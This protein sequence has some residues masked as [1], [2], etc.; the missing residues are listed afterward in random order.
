MPLAIRA[1]L[2][3]CLVAWGDIACAESEGWKDLAAPESQGHWVRPSQGLDS[4]P[5]WGHADGL[6][7]GLAPMPGPR[8]LLRV[9]APYLGHPPGRMINYVAVEPILVGQQRRSFSELEPSRLDGVRGKRFWST[10]TPNDAPPRRP[11]RPARGVVSREGDIETLQ[12]FIHV[13]RFDSGAHPYLRLRF[14]SDRPHE[15]AIAAFAH[16]DS[17][18]LL[19][20]IVTAT[21]GNYARLRRLHLADRVVLARDLWPRFDSNGFAPAR[22]FPLGQLTRTARGHAVISATTN[23][24]KPQDA[25]YAPGTFHGWK[26]QGHRAVQ[27]W[28]CEDPPDNLRV[29]VNGRTRYWASQSPI[30][31]GISYENFEMVAGFRDGQEFWF[32]VEPEDASRRPQR[33]TDR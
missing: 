19:A 15:V 30:P 2:L 33:A 13:E 22:E 7:I 27:Y 4:Q 1:T 18:P 28:R 12:V 20:C 24:R 3:C 17:K 10:D 9:Y 21:M 6:R 32:G 23:E 11:Q 16:D 25:Q 29:R 5:V 8:G 14:R 31:G 26:Y